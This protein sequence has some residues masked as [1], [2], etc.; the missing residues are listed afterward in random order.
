[1]QVILFST[2]IYCKYSHS[3]LVYLKVQVSLSSLI[4]QVKFSSNPIMQ[5]S[6]NLLLDILQ[7]LWNFLDILQVPLTILFMV[8]IT[9]MNNIEQEC[10]SLSNESN[11]KCFR[12]R[13]PL[14]LWFKNLF[15]LCFRGIVTWISIPVVI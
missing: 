10:M 13:I 8:Q 12:L 9:Y 14:L 4:V 15:K 5:V 3:S 2:C 6:W 1:M 7:V 11:I